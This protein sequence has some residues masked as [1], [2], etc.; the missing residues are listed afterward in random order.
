[1]WTEIKLAWNIECSCDFFGHFVY[2]ISIL[3]PVKTIAWPYLWKYSKRTRDCSFNPLISRTSKLETFKTWS[4]VSI[5]FPL[6]ALE[7]FTFNPKRFCSINEQFPYWNQ[8]TYSI[9]TLI[10]CRSEGVKTYQC[11]DSVWDILYFTLIIGFTV[12]DAILEGAVAATVAANVWEIVQLTTL[13]LYIRF[14]QQKNPVFKEVLIW[15]I[16]LKNLT[17]RMVQG[18]NLCNQNFHHHHHLYLYL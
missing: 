7:T 12:A 11:W 1:M 13:P 15:K 9:L 8:S 14:W 2:G 18:Y 17:R 6:I 4:S 5:H 3:F 10:V 16:Y